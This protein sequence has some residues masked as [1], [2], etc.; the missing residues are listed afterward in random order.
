MTGKHKASG[1]DGQG[2]GEGTGQGFE[3]QSHAGEREKQDSEKGTHML[4]IY[5]CLTLSGFP[6]L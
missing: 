4:K 2:L 1:P 6:A 3:R 5:S